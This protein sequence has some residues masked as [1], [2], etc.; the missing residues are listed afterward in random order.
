MIKCDVCDGKNR[1]KK[2]LRAH[3][4]KMHGVFVK[5]IQ[6]DQC[7]FITGKL[8]DMDNHKAIKHYDGYRKKDESRKRVIFS[9]KCPFMNCESTFD[10]EQKL[11]KHNLDQHLGPKPMRDTEGFEDKSPPRKK[12]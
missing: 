5:N 11:R 7:D 10:S 12:A 8:L 6:C 3:R 4:E 9:F 2:F 1:E